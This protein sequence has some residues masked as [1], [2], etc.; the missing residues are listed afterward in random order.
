[1]FRHLLLLIISICILQIACSPRIPQE[2]Q[3]ADPTADY[4][5]Y[6]HNAINY[7]SEVGF[8]AEFGE[9]QAQDFIVRW[10]IGMEVYI[11]G[12]TQSDID[13]VNK[14]IGELAQ[15]TGLSIKFT[16]Q[17]ISTVKVPNNAINIRYTTQDAFAEACGEERYEKVVKYHGEQA[18]YFCNGWNDNSKIIVHAYVLIDNSI[19]PQSQ[20]NHLLREEL[21]QSLGIMKDSNSYTDSVFH[22]SYS[23]TPTEFSELDKQV[24]QIL[25]DNRISA[26]MNLNDILHNLEV[27]KTSQQQV[28]QTR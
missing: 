27:N 28:A 16:N 1:M 24:I 17:P 15:L 22:D 18:G 26:G 4:T 7:F 11:N 23:S 13:E 9:K 2:H 19:Q 3:V 6:S 12:G 21:T 25:Y 10:E 14:V 20:R 8:G 5:P